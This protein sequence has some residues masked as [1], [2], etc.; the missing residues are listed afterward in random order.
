MIK[1]ESKSCL[2]TVGVTLGAYALAELIHHGVIA[3]YLAPWL[4]GLGLSASMI[5]YISW[6]AV[7]LSVVAIGWL[8]WK[9]FISAEA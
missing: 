4:M 3:G 5:A 9:F 8:I 6:A 2:T 7:A 1:T